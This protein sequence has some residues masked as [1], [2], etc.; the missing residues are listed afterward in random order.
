MFVSMWSFFTFFF[1]IFSHFFTFFNV[2]FFTLDILEH[3]DLQS[4][5]FLCLSWIVEPK[6][7]IYHWI[8]F[9]A[10]LSAFV[11]P[12]NK[13]A[14]GNHL[15]KHCKQFAMYMQAHY[16]CHLLNLNH[17]LIPRIK[18]SYKQSLVV[19]CF[20]SLLVEVVRPKKKQRCF[21]KW[22][23]WKEFKRYQTSFFMN[24]KTKHLTQWIV[25][26]VNFWA[27]ERIWSNCAV[28]HPYTLSKICTF[29]FPGR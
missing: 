14:L 17:Q 29:S 3:F 13:N 26:C 11:S 24:C 12:E 19:Q 10:W 9:G 25:N 2:K 22:M 16:I 23:T 1:H 28:P 5:L 20:L 21:W 7:C 27:I 18:Q 4:L 15:T 6:Q 8:V